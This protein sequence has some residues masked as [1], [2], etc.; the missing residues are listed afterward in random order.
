MNNIKAKLE[1]IFEFEKELNILLDE[2]DYESFKQQQDLFAAQLKDFLKKYSQAE[3][4]EEITQLKRLD[5]L[6]EKL[7]ERADIDAKKLKAQ[8]LK[9][10][11]NKSKINAYK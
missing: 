10:Q 3:L 6:V 9:M 2:E 11:R 7:R 5:D 8:S 4:N 1:Q